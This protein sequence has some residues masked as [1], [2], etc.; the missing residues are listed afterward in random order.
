MLAAI[1]TIIIAFQPAPALTPTAMS[2][3]PTLF[4]VDIILIAAYNSTTESNG[5]YT[6]RTYHYTS[7]WDVRY[8]G[9]GTG[10]R[11]PVF[12]H[13]GWRV[14]RRLVECS[15]G[16]GDVS[17]T[18]IVIAPCVVYLSADHDVE[19]RNRQWHRKLK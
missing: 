10:M 5:K 7:Y 4:Y 1:L 3:E 13:R 18:R 17:R 11:I 19:L 14:S 15:G 9:Y 16:F 8:F 12:C 2:D 6:H